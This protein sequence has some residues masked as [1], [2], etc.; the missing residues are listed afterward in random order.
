MFARQCSKRYVF[1]FIFLGNHDDVCGVPID[2]LDDSI[3]DA[4]SDRIK[5]TITML[6]GMHKQIKSF[7]RGNDDVELDLDSFTTNRPLKPMC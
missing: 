7:Q 1:S 2:L 4:L 6:R 3:K 5:K